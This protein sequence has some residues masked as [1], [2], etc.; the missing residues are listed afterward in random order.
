MRVEKTVELRADAPSIWR[1]LTDPELTAKY[2]FACRACSDWE[3][4]SELLYKMEH[5]GETI[6]AVRGVILAIEPERFLKCT[7]IAA[8]TEGQEG[9]ET[10]VTYTL[11][12]KGEVTE[13]AITQ[14]EFADDGGQ[15]K[16]SESWN[17]VLTGL[18]ELVEG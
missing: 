6:V 9:A 4:G 11:T 8:G 17:I 13:L 16:H 12:P 2:F 10:T 7:C 14:G 15:E 5:E 18:K 3:V 1:A